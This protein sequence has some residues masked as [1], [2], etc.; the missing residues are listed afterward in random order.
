M[1]SIIIPKI[2]MKKLRPT[3]LARLIQLLL[4][5]EG[6]I[7]RSPNLDLQTLNSHSLSPPAPH[8]PTPSHFNSHWIKVVNRELMTKIKRRF[9]TEMIDNNRKEVK[10]PVKASIR[11]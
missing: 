1:I 2:P 4:V 3:D 5:A 6:L 9:K 8:P 7:P 11:N 10:G